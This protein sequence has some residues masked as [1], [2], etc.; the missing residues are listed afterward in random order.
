[1]IQIVDAHAGENLEE[2]RQL[3]GEYAASL[4]ISLD[5]QGFDA[6][7]AN[8]P[9][10]YAPPTGCLLVARW[11]GAVVGCIALRKLD[12]GVCE[13]KRLYTRPAFRGLKIGKALSEAAIQR[14]RELGY[15]RMRLDTLRSMASARTLYAALGFREIEPYCYNPID[16]AIFMELTLA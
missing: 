4:E 12:D 11:Q 9:G 16:G 14:A 6:E 5:F 8:L 10:V 1:M 13:M 15:S 3:F 2:A 7:L